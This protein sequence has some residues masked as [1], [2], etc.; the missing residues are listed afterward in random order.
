MSL[1]FGIRIALL[2]KELRPQPKKGEI[3]TMLNYYFFPL[4][5]AFGF[6]DKYGVVTLIA[7]SFYLSQSIYRRS[8]V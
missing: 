7:V 3:I 2:N 8:L 1:T 6:G 4:Q 5:L